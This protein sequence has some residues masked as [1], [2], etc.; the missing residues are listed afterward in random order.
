MITTDF[1]RINKV[2]EPNG[3]FSCMSNHLVTH[4]GLIYRTCEALFQCLRFKGYPAI[5][6]MIR[7]EKSPMGAKMR[8]RK[9]CG[10][11]NRGPKWDEA[12]GD[13]DLMMISLRLKIEQHPELIEELLKTGDA[14]II[15]DCTS[16]DRESS[17]FWGMVY[18]EN[19]WLGENHLGNLWME[20]RDELKQKNKIKETL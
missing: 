2:R 15:E 17:R 20:I 9:H 16:H 19:N 18:K 5:Q 11:L 12:P 7:S 3:N 1:I 8:A 4:E 6:E 10:L 14:K 13:L